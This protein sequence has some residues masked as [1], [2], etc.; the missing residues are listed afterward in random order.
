MQE[1]GSVD[2]M[3]VRLLLDEA[4]SAYSRGD[5]VFAQRLYAQAFRKAEQLGPEAVEMVREERRAKNFSDLE[6]RERDRD[7]SQDTR[8]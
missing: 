4:A 6:T 5:A 2:T 3:A 7:W 8:D 1:D